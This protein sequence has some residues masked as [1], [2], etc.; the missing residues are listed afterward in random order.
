MW[1][2]ETLHSDIKFGIKGKLICRK[3]TPYQDC[4]IYQ[5]KD[6]G[7]LLLLDNAIQTTEADEYTYHEMLV[8]PV[9]M[10][11]P[12]PKSI[13]I[14]GGGDGGVLKEVV[15]H[16]VEEIIMVEIDKDVIELSKKYLP[17]LSKRSFLDKRLGLIIDDGAKYIAETEKKFDVVII[18]SPDPIGPA[19]VLF[20]LKFY[21][22]LF[23]VLKADGIVIRQTGSAFLQKKVLKDNY[24]KVSKVFPQ[25]FIQLAAVPTYIGGFFSF[26]I[27]SKKINFLKNRKKALEAKQEKLKLNTKY[28]N[29]KIQAASLRLPNKI[30]EIVK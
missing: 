26:V 21:R 27:G 29:S 5:T 9:L 23:K 12:N 15:K 24:R 14:I 18:D 2:Y 16:P 10:T 17:T 7:R 11:H 3:K 4:R 8:H 6:F 22:D 13:L 28:Y 25:A 20:S 19:K 1:F 30:K